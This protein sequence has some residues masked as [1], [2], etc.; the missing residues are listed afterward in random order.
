MALRKHLS[1]TV[2]LLA[3]TA[4]GVTGGGVAWLL[5]FKTAADAAWAATSLVALVP[6]VV[7]IVRDLIRRSAGVD[8]I[9][10]L[11]IVGALL[12]GEYLAGAVIGLMLAT[13]MALEEFAAN[14]AERELSFFR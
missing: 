9:A 8:V 5:G 4:V 14:R 6:T 1:G 11:A 13:G 2:L 3:A 12:L 7:T 10:V